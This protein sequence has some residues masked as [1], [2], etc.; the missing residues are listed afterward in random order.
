MSWWAAVGTSGAHG[1][2]GSHRHGGLD[3]HCLL[4]AEQR[5]L[6]VEHAC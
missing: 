6:G 2:V 5:Q 1:A 3:A 4:L